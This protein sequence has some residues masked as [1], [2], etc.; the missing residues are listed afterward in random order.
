MLD[1]DADVNPGD[2]ITYSVNIESKS[3]DIY[4]KTNKGKGALVPCN[5][6]Y[7]LYSILCLTLRAD[8]FVATDTISNVTLS[9]P[10]KPTSLSWT[11]TLRF[12]LLMVFVFLKW[13]GLPWHVRKGRPSLEPVDFQFSSSL[14]V[15][16]FKASVH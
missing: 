5:L 3:G 2:S 13:Y 10:T 4:S 1:K 11:A 14:M 15:M 16:L 9:S 6:E 12:P 8:N 7:I